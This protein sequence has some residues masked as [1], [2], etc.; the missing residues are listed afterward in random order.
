MQCQL[1]RDRNPMDV[2]L[3]LIEKGKLKAFY[4]ASR[5]EEDIARQKSRIQWLAGGTKTLH[6]SI[7]L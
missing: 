6:I 4:E 7:I 1:D 5:I 2:D 3:M